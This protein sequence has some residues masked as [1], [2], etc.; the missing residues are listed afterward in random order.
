MGRDKN[1]IGNRRLKELICTTYGRGLREGI[2]EGWSTGWRGD[3][4]GKLGKL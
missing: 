1:S 4:G 3:N 2:L